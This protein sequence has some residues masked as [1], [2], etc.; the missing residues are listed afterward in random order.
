MDKVAEYK[1]HAEDCRHMAKAAANPQHAAALKKM[2]ETWDNLASA[3]AVELQRAK[4]VAEIDGDN[5]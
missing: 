2:A 5:Q 1:L 3:R 4:R